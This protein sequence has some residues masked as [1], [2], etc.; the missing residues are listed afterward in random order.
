[1]QEY[2]PQHYAAA[3]SIV[4]KLE[5][6][7]ADIWNELLDRTL[8]SHVEFDGERVHTVAPRIEYLIEQADALSLQLEAEIKRW[9]MRGRLYRDYVA[10]HP[11][12]TTQDVQEELL[13]IDTYVCYQTGIEPPEE[14]PTASGDVPTNLA[15]M[16]NYFD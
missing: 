1:M 15:I 5:Q 8:T 9:R 16:A 3:S 10:T 13:Q 4:A 7:K 2:N 12:P 6:Q 11:N 14:Q